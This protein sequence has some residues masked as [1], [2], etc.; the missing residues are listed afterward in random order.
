MQTPREI[1]CAQAILEAT[2]ICLEKD[3]NVF[4]IG[5]GVD[6]PKGIFGTT[7]DLHLK[8]GN[9]RVYDTPVSEN[10][11]TGMAIGAAT[12]GKRPILTH[13]RVDFALLSLDQI[14][15]NAAKWHFMFGGQLRCPITIR[16]IIGR[17]W[18]QGPQHSQSL[19]AL[20][21]H[22]A[23]LKVVMPAS[24]HD[25]KGLLISSVEDDDPVIFLEHRWL[26]YMKGPVPSGIYRE[27]IGT[28]KVVKVGTQATVVATSYAVLETFRAAQKLQE[29]GLDIEVIDLRTIKPFDGRTILESVRKTGRLLVVDTGYVTYGVSA[30]MV[31]FV[32]ERLFDQLKSAPR[33]IA[34]P[35][36]PVPT[37]P[38]LAKDY[39]PQ[40]HQIAETLVQMVGKN[41]SDYTSIIDQLKQVESSRPIDVPDLSFSGPF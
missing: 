2:D 41:L 37:S 20:F 11:L 34:C 23:G 7:V 27:R 13:Q 30:E 8:Y 16:M 3:P 24:P 12:M 22:I 36:T 4:L 26:H 1:T 10:A 32:T 19:Q 39:Y 5:L 15:N 40:S 28:A 9:E 33:R 25:A 35:D 6:D 17:G 21:G 38:S 18:G 14:I 29:A 31:A